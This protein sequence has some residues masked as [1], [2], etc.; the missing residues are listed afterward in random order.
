MLAVDILDN[1]I[2]K[3][4]FGMFA[5]VEELAQELQQLVVMSSL[6][7]TYIRFYI[8][9][10]TFESTKQVKLYLDCSYHKTAFLDF[11]W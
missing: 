7:L 4:T 8:H 9:A 1:A 6:A 3:M 11:V 10:F 2:S 5:K